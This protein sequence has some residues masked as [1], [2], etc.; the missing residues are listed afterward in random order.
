MNT[1]ILAQRSRNEDHRLPDTVLGR[2]H[3]RVSADDENG[4]ATDDEGE[5]ILKRY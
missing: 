2:L 3:D 5:C 1:D 4:G